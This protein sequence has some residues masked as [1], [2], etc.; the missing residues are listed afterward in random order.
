M[1]E[2]IHLSTIP[3]LVDTEWLAE[4]L[5][6]PKLRLLDA[7]TF[8]KLKEGGAELISGRDVYLQ[9]HIPGAVFADLIHTFSDTS[10]PFPV[11]AASHDAFSQAIGQ[12]GVGAYHDVIIY[13]QGFPDGSPIS[14][15]IWASRLWWQLRLAGFDQVGVLAGGLAKW[16]AESRPTESGERSYPPA[17]FVG[18]RRPELLAQK[19]DVIA[20]LSDDQ[21]LLIDSLS[22][23]DH[24]GK[25]NSYARNGH[26]PGSVNVF[27]GKLA[28][29][30]T[31]L[32]PDPETLRKQLRASGALDPDKRVITYCGGGIAA[33][34]VALA[35]AHAGRDDVAVYDG[36]R[37]EWTSD[38]A[39]PV[40]GSQH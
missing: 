26:I 35:L 31:H 25:T 18:T 8:L 1:I 5:H 34:W 9:S 24:H 16:Q 15:S 20:A 37:N 32:L 21:T 3:Y 2:V 39:L 40:V 28:D 13:D 11:T 12:L 6:D 23:D 30:T 7:T 36:S 14:A 4:R 17:H 27:F 22:P 10:A 38:P 29:P 19:S 33:T